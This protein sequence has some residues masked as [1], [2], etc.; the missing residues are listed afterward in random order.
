MASG[1]DFRIPGHDCVTLISC[2]R[3]PAVTMLNAL[4]SFIFAVIRHVKQ[5]STLNNLFGH[6]NKEKNPTGGFGM[7]T[8]VDAVHYTSYPLLIV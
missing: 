7:Q 3:S 4:I 5:Y 8:G 6:A 2:S 1:S